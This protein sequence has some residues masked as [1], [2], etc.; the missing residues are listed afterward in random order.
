MAMA[1]YA[2]ARAGN[3]FP[4]GVSN[5]EAW[6][7]SWPSRAARPAFC[8]REVDNSA[9]G[10]PARRRMACL[11]T[12]STGTFLAVRRRRRRRIGSLFRILSR[13]V[14]ESSGQ[15]AQRNDGVSD[16]KPTDVAEE[17]QDQ[18]DY[19]A[20]SRDELV[21]EEL[22]LLD[23]SGAFTLQKI[24]EERLEKR[25][26]R[27]QK[28]SLLEAWD[29][30]V[31][32]VRNDTERR[33]LWGDLKKKSNPA[34]RA[35][36]KRRELKELEIR[37]NR[38]F[39][40]ED[41]HDEEEEEE[42]EDEPA[43]I[44]VWR[45]AWPDEQAI[46]PHDPESFGFSYIGEITGA[47]GIHGEVRIRVDDDLVEMGMEPEQY[48][49]VRNFSNWTEKPKRVH[50]KQPHRRFPRPFRIIS[51]K[52][53]Q[54]RVFAVQLKGVTT[55]QEAMEL[56]GT[57]IFVLE[58]PEELQEKASD[59]ADAA[60]V[61]LYDSLTTS[62]STR[63]ALELVDAQCYQLVGNCSDDALAEFAFAENPE[64]AQDVLDRYE[65]KAVSFGAVSA[66]VPDYKIARRHDARK[67][68]HDLL[69]ITLKPEISAGE[70][71]YLYDPD[72]N[73]VF[74]KY[75]NVPTTPEHWERVLYV[76]FVPDML[77][78]IDADMSGKKSVY[79]TLPQGHVEKC[80][81]TCRKRVVNEKGLLA[82]PRMSNVKALLPPAGKSVAVRR[83]QRAR[84]G[85]SPTPSGA[86]ASPGMPFPEPR[87]GVPRPPVRRPD[88]PVPLQEF[89]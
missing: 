25:R 85:T 89:A 74:G 18:L 63:D 3:A 70:G 57:Q 45:Q 19:V 81:F 79:F 50:L 84:N 14:G 62:F 21:A 5:D 59:S 26:Q 87:P 77:A 55:V 58:T 7:K 76:P 8:A 2:Q 29:D 78:R 12:A 72:P 42:S 39:P 28:K 38:G 52:R 88:E 15:V 1:C 32:E 47:H 27:D 11:A 41:W 36:G 65:I 35:R 20:P 40:V 61:D 71:N 13:A 80:S 51:G 64:E 6:C 37:N 53:V 43:W 33:R 69:D 31:E 30:D 82:I 56:R 16:A 48:L 66:V 44:D 24:E 4:H 46:D 17:S 34:R 75:F 10:D 86:P 68:A 60:R 49:S 73:S 67:A 9:C 54:R 83:Q 23:A 22:A